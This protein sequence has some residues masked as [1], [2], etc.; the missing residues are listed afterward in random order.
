MLYFGTEILKL[1][2]ENTK[3]EITLSAVDITKSG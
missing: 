3:T 1:E 2:F